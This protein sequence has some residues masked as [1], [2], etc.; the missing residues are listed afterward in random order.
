LEEG[1]E[2]G[3]GEGRFA[4]PNERDKHHGRHHPRKR[5]IQ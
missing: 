5:V 1:L 3:V 4:N 2:G